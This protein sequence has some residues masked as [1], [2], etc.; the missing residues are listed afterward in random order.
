MSED[1]K[2]TFNGLVTERCR[3]YFG[4]RYAY[5]ERFE[6]AKPVEYADGTTV[7]ATSH[8]PA[9]PQLRQFHQHLDNPHRLFYYK[10]F[11]EGIEFEYG[12]DCLVLDVYAPL[13]AAGCPV[14]LFFHGGGFDSGSI[15][16]GA[17]DGSLFA[18]KGVVT[19]FAQYRVGV[20]GYLTDESIEKK[21]GRD[22]NFGLDDQIK[23]LEWVR[24]YIGCLGGDPENITLAGQ[25]AG[26]ISIQY[27]CLNRDLE[28]RF[29]R[30][31]MMSGGGKFPDFALPKYA[32]E[33]RPY[34]KALME[35]A[36]CSSLEELKV[37][38]LDRLFDAVDELKSKRK[39]TVYNTMP[40]VDGCL[41]PE[42]VG[43]LIKNPL[44]VG[45]MIGYTNTDMYAPV[46]EFIGNKFGKKNGAYIYFFDIDA[47]GDGNGAFHSCDLRYMFGTLDKS[48]RPYGD[49][50]REASC[51]LAT[52]A[53][54]FAKTGDPN[55]PYL[56]EW[57]PAKPGAGTRVLTL[58]PGQT[59]MGK[60]P[61]LR[62]L[63]NML[64]KGDP[65]A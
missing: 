26:A 28:G 10:E 29:R 1:K 41:I 21:Y 56:P 49:R 48:R 44:K 4:I 42:P 27:M 53:A 15:T 50:D 22:G 9:C 24:K 60:A 46:M 12:E 37:L 61:Y 65:K 57:L 33:T 25:S 23:A 19:V 16:E 3:Q 6:Y 14:I 62:L 58:A 43:K 7:D 17:F 13:D 2:V 54:N 11:R 47:P 20:L 64:T 36:G 5:A 31:I 51:Q 55:G 59:S 40:V 35:T 45:Y 18:E 39:D 8:G 52:Y 38:P 30:V 63:K 32:A 34:W